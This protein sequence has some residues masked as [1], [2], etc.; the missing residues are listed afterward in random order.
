M[1]SLY[2]YIFRWDDLR[3]AVDVSLMDRTFRKISGDSEILS[4]P[5]VRE[6]LIVAELT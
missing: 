2:L 1:R 4:V 3:I 6:V 5:S